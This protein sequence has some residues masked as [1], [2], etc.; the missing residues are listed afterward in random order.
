VWALV[1]NIRADAS[2]IDPVT[3]THLR[4]PKLREAIAH[5]VDRDRIAREVFKGMATVVHGPVSPGNQDWST[6]N[7]KQY[8]FDPAA[9]LAALDAD[10]YNEGAQQRKYF[11]MGQA[12]GRQQLYDPADRAVHFSLYY[13]KDDLA[14]EMQKIIVA[15]LA[16]LGI[17][18]K[19]I[20]VD[21]GKFMSQR[22]AK[23][24]FDLALCRIDGG[25][26][27][28]PISYMPVFMSNGAKHYHINIAPDADVTPDLDFEKQVNRL[29]RSQQAEPLVDARKQDFYK[30]QQQSA[31]NV[32]AV[33][34][35]ADNVL[36]ASSKLGNFK[37]V[38]TQPYVLWNAEQLFFKP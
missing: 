18:V 6:R 38:T 23:G 31:Q 34:I 2:L 13:P 4:R 32:P 33:Y 1:L 9:A 35:V 3:A 27:A 37:A 7:V 8:Q 28:D 17:P 14:E 19:P 12:D 21:H 29:M 15:Q 24:A 11:R 16:A 10:T 30:V 26:G 36:L 25:L 20:A 22:L 5:S